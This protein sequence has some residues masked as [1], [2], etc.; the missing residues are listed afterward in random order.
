[1]LLIYNLRDIEMA[2]FFL[3]NFEDAYAL[4]A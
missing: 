1:V 4:K 3:Q 2:M